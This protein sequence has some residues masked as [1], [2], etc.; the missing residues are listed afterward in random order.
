MELMENNALPLVAGIRLQLR[1]FLT[2]FEH[3]FTLAFVPLSLQV[4]LLQSESSP[5]MGTLQEE[6]PMKVF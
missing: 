6:Q 2:T 3:S 1:P 5:G 4:L